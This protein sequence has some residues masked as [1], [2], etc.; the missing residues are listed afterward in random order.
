[1][2]KIALRK[3]EP[4]FKLMRLHQPVGVFLL[5]WPCLI[6]LSLASRG[7]IDFKL[8]MVF[9]IGSILMRSAGCIINDLAD[10]KFDHAVNRTRLR[11]LVSGAIKNSQAIKLLIVLLLLS[12]SL[13]FFLN[14]IAII[15]SIS[16]IP[17]VFLYPFCKRFTYWPQVFLG[18]TYNIG[19]LVAWAAVRGEV[20]KAAIALYIA[21]IFWTIGYDTIYAHQDREDDLKIGLK[22]TAIKFGDKTE[23]I[24]NIFYTIT[25][26]MLVL[27]GGLVGIY[28]HY[29]A[30]LSLPIAL[31]FWQVTTLDINNRANCNLRFKSNILVGGFIL[32]A[33]L[34]A[35]GF[36]W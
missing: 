3:I 22:S 31:L 7:Y 8:V 34:I 20:N 15:I 13:L 10:H 17:F 24:L 29:Y 9:I 19:A 25:S 27:V 30:F 23:K 1:M 26:T 35:K 14:K 21:F 36:I 32:L 12:A 28:Y 5:L 18:V 11:P 6:S 4:Y 33:V 16:I 2:I